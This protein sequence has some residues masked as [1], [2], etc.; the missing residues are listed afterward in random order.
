YYASKYEGF[1]IVS[2]EMQFNYDADKQNQM[3][4]NPEAQ[5]YRVELDELYDFVD[6]EGH[7]HRYLKFI[8]AEYKEPGNLFLIKSNEAKLNQERFDELTKLNRVIPYS[9]QDF[10][11]PY[12]QYWR[13]KEGVFHKIQNIKNEDLK[14]MESFEKFYA[15]AHRFIGEQQ[16]G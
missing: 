10:N 5:V 13:T 4:F 6:F 16:E 3:I 2:K 8:G 7:S 15:K 11:P 14:S 9:K 12:R 1:K